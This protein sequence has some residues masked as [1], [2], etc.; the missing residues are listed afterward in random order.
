[1]CNVRYRID[2]QTRQEEDKEEEAN[3]ECVFVVLSES[4]KLELEK[5]I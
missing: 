1:M 4:S 5:I 2:K 3:E